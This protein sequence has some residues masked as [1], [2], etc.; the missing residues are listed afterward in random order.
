MQLYFNVETEFNVNEKTA[1]LK[2]NIFIHTI[3]YHSILQYHNQ[4]LSDAFFNWESQDTSDSFVV[5]FSYSFFFFKICAYAL[6]FAGHFRFDNE[7]PEHS[8][9]LC[10][11]IH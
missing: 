2:E 10:M 8:R 3:I 11:A 5:I 4:N 7:I 6:N 9:L 1:N